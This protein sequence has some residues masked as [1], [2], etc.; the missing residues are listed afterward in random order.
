VEFEHATPRAFKNAINNAK[1]KNRHGWM[2][3]T[4]TKKQFRNNRNSGTAY[5]LSKDHKTGLAITKD[6]NVEAVFSR[7]RGRMPNIMAFA[8]AR[9][10]R[11]LDCYGG[12]LQNMYARYGAKATGYVEWNDDLAPSDWDGR[13]RLPVV[14]MILPKGLSAMM[15]SYD[16]S[17][18]ISLGRVKNYHSDWDG[19]MADRE[20]KMSRGSRV[21][22]ALRVAMGSST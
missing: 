4:H 1:R 21:M 2:V 22:S 10:G 15:R 6:G 18:E 11:K 13:T 14:A 17:R 16:P 7:T 5:Y 20:R 8:A 9:G 19:M 12:G 3:D